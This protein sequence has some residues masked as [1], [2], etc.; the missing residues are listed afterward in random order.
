MGKRVLVA[1]DDNSPLEGL[2][3]YGIRLAARIDSGLAVIAVSSSKDEKPSSVS[4]VRLKDVD[5]MQLGWLGHVMDEGRRHSVNMEIFI[6]GGN[7]FDG[8]IRLVRSQP[9]IQF[10]VVAAPV[11][12]TGPYAT[13]FTASLKLLRSKFE[14]EILVVE[15]TGQINQ[16][17]DECAQSSA[18]GTR[19]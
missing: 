5:E 11:R 15:K 10:V 9:T 19:V 6:T 16:V 1:I 14:G 17:P 2:I 13:N 12:K 8:V 7:L 18:K 4:Q 3:T